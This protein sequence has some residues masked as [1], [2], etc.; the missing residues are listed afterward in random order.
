MGGEWEG[1]TQGFHLHWSLGTLPG[2]QTTPSSGAQEAKA[3]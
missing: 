2:P 3:R 1:E